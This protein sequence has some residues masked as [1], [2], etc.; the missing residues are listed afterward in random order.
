MRKR[1]RFMKR[2]LEL[3]CEM[4]IIAEAWIMNEGD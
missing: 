2:E 3:I 4:I 1:V